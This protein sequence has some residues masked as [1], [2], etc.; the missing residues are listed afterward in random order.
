MT[1]IDKFI[2]EY[3]KIECSAEGPTVLPID[4]YRLFSFTRKF[5]YKVEVEI[6]TAKGMTAKNL[7]R[8][9]PSAKIYTVDPYVAYSE[10]RE[11][12]KDKLDIQK[13][14]AES[15]LSIFPSSRCEMITD[16][17]KNAV[18]RF[19]DESI[20]FVFIDGNH[21]LRYAIEDISIWTEKVKPGGI[22]SG[23][24]FWNSSEGFGYKRLNIDH[25]AKGLTEREK[26]TICQVK[27]AVLLWT[28][29]N[30]IT[31]WYLT[32]ADDCACWFWVKE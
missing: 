12:G 29:A 7:C 17:S 2:E 21:T 19:E 8:Y 9:N 27:D 1:E 24:D 31:P 28:E 22:I 5:G 23:H 11:R 13:K 6:G 4:M 14:I 32:G 10:Y 30:K 16:F 3:C 15:R 18:N 20:D 26:E 25:F